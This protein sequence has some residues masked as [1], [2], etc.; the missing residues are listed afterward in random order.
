M[1]F[2]FDIRFVKNEHILSLKGPLGQSKVQGNP[3]ESILESPF[4]SKS[5]VKIKNGTMY[6]IFDIRFVKNEHILSLKWPLGHSKVQGNA[7]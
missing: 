2:I 6:F 7:S 3:R 4:Q 5:C 1:Y